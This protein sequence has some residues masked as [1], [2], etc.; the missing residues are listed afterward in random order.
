MTEVCVKYLASHAVSTRSDEQGNGASI[1]YKQIHKLLMLS[2]LQKEVALPLVVLGH[3]RW[4]QV[5]EL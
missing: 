5:S 3:A 4:W 2:R 1:I